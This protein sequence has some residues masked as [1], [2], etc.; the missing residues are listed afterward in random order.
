MNDDFPFLLPYPDNKTRYYAKFNIDLF[1]AIN[2][3]YDISKI[4]LLVLI[5]VIEQ[6]AS[7]QQ[8]PC[9]F[10]YRELAKKIGCVSDS[11]NKSVHAL[12]RWGL[13]NPPNERKGRA[14]SEYVPNKDKLHSLLLSYWDY[15]YGEDAPHRIMREKNSQNF[16]KKKKQ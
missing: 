13:L 4:D 6:Y 5:H 2:R 1:T 11:V 10:S 12:L 8:T 15:L 16:L 3:K 14:K 9:K 7:N